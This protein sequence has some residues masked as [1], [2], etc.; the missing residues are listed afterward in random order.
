LELDFR[1]TV[2]RFQILLLLVLALT[3]C[4]GKQLKT[5]QSLS[6]QTTITGCLTY[7]SNKGQYVLTDRNGEKTFV[8]AEAQDLKLQGAGNQTVRVVGV[9][10]R[11]ANSNRIIA[12]QIDHLANYCTTPF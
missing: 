10:D 4:A 1:H 8:V 12:T 5:A 11:L 3:G 6:G 2:V 9:G 7:D